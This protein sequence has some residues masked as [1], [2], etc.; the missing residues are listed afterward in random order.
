MTLSENRLQSTVKDSPNYIVLTH[1]GAYIYLLYKALRKRVGWEMNGRS[2]DLYRG[3]Y[4]QGSF[5]E[6]KSLFLPQIVIFSEKYL[7]F[8]K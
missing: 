3:N 1:A 7:L 6:E 2:V 5:L 8:R 4:L